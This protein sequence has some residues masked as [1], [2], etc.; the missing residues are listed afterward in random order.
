M[1]Q[2]VSLSDPRRLSANVG[3][4]V[5]TSSRLI[6]M[7]AFRNARGT[8]MLTTI[9]SVNADKY[10]KSQLFPDFTVCALNLDY[11]QWPKY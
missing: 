8:F 4:R 1:A 6:G 3:L 7:I 9:P 10:C 5:A 11:K 2:N